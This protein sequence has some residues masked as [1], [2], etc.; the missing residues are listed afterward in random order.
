MDKEKEQLLAN[1]KSVAYNIAI[2]PDDLKESSSNII[3]FSEKYL[4]DLLEILKKYGTITTYDIDKSLKNGKWFR[5]LKKIFLNDTHKI[6]LSNIIKRHAF[7]YLKEFERDQR[8]L[9]LN[10]IRKFLKSCSN[11]SKYHDSNIIINKY[12]EL[13]EGYSI[14]RAVRIQNE[15]VSRVLIGD[16]P[17]L[18]SDYV[19]AYAKYALKITEILLNLDSI[20][21]LVEENK[22]IDV[23]TINGFNSILNNLEDDHMEEVKELLRTIA[24]Y[25]SGCIKNNRV[26]NNSKKGFKESII[27]TNQ[28]SL[29]PREQRMQE[30]AKAK[31]SKK[32]VEEVQINKNDIEIPINVKNYLESFMPIVIDDDYSIN[33]ALP[34]KGTPNYELIINQMLVEVQKLIDDELASDTLIKKRDALEDIAE[35]M[36]KK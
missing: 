27:H 32:V 29:I 24:R 19:E 33:D 11:F 30:Y 18:L 23:K 3:A 26:K 20:V 2:D 16:L 35:N 31:E 6:I 4:D 17:L 9:K 15:L 12:F 7:T 25:N 36:Y 1:L 8:T 22:M 10:G 21:S 34:Q 5:D 13:L 14:N 28:K